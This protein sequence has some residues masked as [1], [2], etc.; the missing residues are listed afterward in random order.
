MIG[1]P[2]PF[3]KSPTKNDVQTKAYHLGGPTCFILP[4]LRL[5]NLP[6]LHLIAVIA[7]MS[8]GG[9][10]GAAP[11][12]RR[13]A[14]QTRCK[15]ATCGFKTGEFKIFFIIYKVKILNQHLLVQTK[16]PFEK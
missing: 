9:P 10:A 6:L 3:E 8:S 16:T 2:T 12:E 15:A 14:R 1:G 11:H 5:P 13:Q 7:Y 4:S